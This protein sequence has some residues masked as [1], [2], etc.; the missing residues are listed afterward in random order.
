MTRIE[1]YGAYNPYASGA[2]Y[3]INWGQQNFG[4]NKN[5]D[6]IQAIDTKTASTGR[7]N[8]TTS[9]TSSVKYPTASPAAAK[10]PTA[11]YDQYDKLERHPEMKD[12]YRAKFLD[13]MA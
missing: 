10:S 9:G 13:Y 6:N 2:G 3:N 7:L 4:G 8:G 12:E 5:E 1:R 11:R